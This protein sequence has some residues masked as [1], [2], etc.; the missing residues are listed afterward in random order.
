MRVIDQI[1]VNTEQMRAIEARMFEAGMPV[2]AL[3]EKVGLMLARRVQELYP[4]PQHFSIGVLVGP[5]HNGADAL[6]AARELHLRGYQVAVWAPLESKKQ[7]NLDHAQYLRSLGVPWV[8]DV[9]EMTLPAVWLDGL[10]GF[11]LDRLI[12]AE[13]AGGD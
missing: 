7:L 1:V 8:A 3:M 4:L 10:F 13:V 12:E 6:V 2:A 9:A 5:G 11:G